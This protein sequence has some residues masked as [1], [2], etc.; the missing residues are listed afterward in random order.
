M[1]WLILAMLLVGVFLSA[2]FS[3]SETGFYRVNRL[4]LVMDGM[5]GD[6]VARCLLWLTNN[7]A[8][9]IATTLVGNNMANYLTSLAIVLLIGEVW[10]EEWV[11]LVGPVAVSPL[12]FVYCELLPKNLFYLAPN[13]LL[14]RGGLLFLLFA[15]LF[16]PVSALLWALG[17]VL[18]RLV[19]ASPSQARL[20]LARKELQK[21]FEEGHEIG[22]LLPAQRT[23]AQN[24]FAVAGRPVI[25]FATPI[26]R[27][28]S[29]KLGMKKSEVLRLARRHR[30][31]AMP[32]RDSTGPEPIG[33]L[34]I[35]DVCLEESETI[36]SVRPML[37]FR[38]TE[39]HSAALIRMQSDKETLARVVDDKD[40]TVALL[41]LNK[42]TE[43]LFRGP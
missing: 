30:V 43:P 18:Q 23:L 16:A 31:S 2:F 42:L 15:I 25:Q 8:L 38:Q 40:S 33:Y 13:R 37:K 1:I 27:V 4:R 29:V 12:V 19:G 6:W 24:L 28:A 14:R 39:P 35:A 5:G 22:I 41:P 10:D 3:G 34:R 32:V 9:F 21:I 11:E 26:A 7:P 20:A 36:T 17:R